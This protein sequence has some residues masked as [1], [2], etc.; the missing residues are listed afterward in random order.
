MTFYLITVT[1][2]CKSLC[3][4]SQ[5]AA[6]YHRILIYGISRYVV[7]WEQV[8]TLWEYVINVHIYRVITSFALAHT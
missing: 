5:T 7:L 3:K 4:I 8:V 1:K 2:S 6:F